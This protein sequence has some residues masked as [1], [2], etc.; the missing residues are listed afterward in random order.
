MYTV[1]ESE[2]SE[3]WYTKLIISVLCTAAGGVLAFR[4]KVATI[5]LWKEEMKEPLGG[6][7]Y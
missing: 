4:E 1:S 5:D 7:T 2:A 3:P 6:R